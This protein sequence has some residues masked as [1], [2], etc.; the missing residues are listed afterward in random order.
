MPAVGISRPT[1]IRGIRLLDEII[2]QEISTSF[3]ALVHTTRIT[4][5]ELPPFPDLATEVG[6]SFP[7]VSWPIHWTGNHSGSA[8]Y[9]AAAGLSEGER[10]QTPLRR[11]PVLGNQDNRSITVCQ[12]TYVPIMRTAPK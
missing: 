7:Y 6:I 12:S 8:K 4:C 11:T 5:P 10:V 2:A 1:V 3:R 9:G